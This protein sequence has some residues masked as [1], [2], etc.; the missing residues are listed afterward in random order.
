MM[1]WYHFNDANSSIGIKKRV[2]LAAFLYGKNVNR[3][4]G[5]TIRILRK[6]HAIYFHF[7]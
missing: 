2:K 5:E 7:L 1:I 6:K 4:H 3:G